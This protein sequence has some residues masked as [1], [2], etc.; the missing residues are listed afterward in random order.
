[1]TSWQNAAAGTSGFGDASDEMAQDIRIA[2]STWRFS[3]VRCQSSTSVALAFQPS[4][5]EE[6]SASQA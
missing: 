6:A 1:M 3:D 2:E 5:P 4:L